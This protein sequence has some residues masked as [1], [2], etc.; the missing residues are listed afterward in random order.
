MQV[1]FQH[2]YPTGLT[3]NLSSEMEQCV[4]RKKQKSNT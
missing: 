3:I 1:G 2:P 4:V